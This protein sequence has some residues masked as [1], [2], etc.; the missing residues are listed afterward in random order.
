MSSQTVIFI[1]V[2]IYMLVMLGVGFYASKKSNSVTDFMIAGRSMPNRA[3]V[4]AV[5]SSASL[6]STSG[7]GP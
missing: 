3:Q 6:S 7:A 4:P 2:A 1:G 5:A